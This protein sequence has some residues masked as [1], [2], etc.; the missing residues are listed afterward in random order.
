MLDRIYNWIESLREK[1]FYRSLNDLEHRL[2]QAE[3]DSQRK[4]EV[5]DWIEY[6][7]DSE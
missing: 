2:M 5:T 1:R 6:D 3:L 7:F 4:I